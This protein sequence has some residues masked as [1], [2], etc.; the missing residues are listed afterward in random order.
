MAGLGIEPTDV[1]TAPSWKQQT[2]LQQMPR[3][4]AGS[5]DVQACARDAAQLAR[6]R[7]NPDPDQAAQFSRNLVCEDLRPQVQ[8]LL[9][10]LGRG[11]AAHPSSLSRAEGAPPAPSNLTEP[12]EP[13]NLGEPAAP[14]SS[15][16]VCK[17]EADELSRIRA[18]PDR[19]AAQRFASQ[20]KCASLKA[21][22]ARLLESLGD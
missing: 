3:S 2:I 1:A 14:I 8:R 11:T 15:A 9:E 13:A 20:L 6:L 4:T 16:E 21:Q 12:R 17:H 5:S 22:A 18:A 19:A 10:S 7:A